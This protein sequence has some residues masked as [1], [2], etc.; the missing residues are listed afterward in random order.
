MLSMRLLIIAVLFIAVLPSLSGALDL[1]EA[2]MKAKQNDPEYL[3]ALYEHRATLTLPE[4]AV[5]RVLPQLSFF[6]SVSNYRFV[7]DRGVYNDYSAEQGVLSFRQTIFDLPSFIEISQSDK[8][9]KAS[10]AKLINAELNLIRRVSDAYFEYIYAEEFLRV[11]REEKKA[12]EQQLTLA[13]RLFEAGESSLTDVHDAEARYYDV[14]F[15]ETE[16]E[17]NLHVKRRNLERLIGEEPKQVLSL[18]R[19]LIFENL[20]PPDVKGWSEIVRNENPY[21]RFFALQ[22]EIAEDELRKQ[23]AQW[24]PNLS[25]F[26]SFTRT[27]TRDYLEV[28]P[29]S[30]VTVGVQINWNIL[31][32]GYY[33]AKTKEARERLNQ[34]QKDY[35]KALSDMIQGVV[36][37]FFSVKS[38]QASILSTESLVRANELALESTKKGFAAG[39]RTF[40]D[41]LNAEANLYKAKL[42]FVKSNHDYVKSLINLYFYSGVLSEE[43]I[44]KINSWLSKNE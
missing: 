23:K 16:A 9:T 15:R 25:I 18:Q 40:V 38:S 20:V 17:R 31:S 43:H 2:Y 11:L 39:I 1:F 21:V 44:R 5:S 10:E 41:I 22:R 24:L 3:S 30:Y 35:E 42:N 36:D 13:K 29:L 14:L 6:Y 12:F 4:Q 33:D 32:G 8:R 28:K 34:A 37:S 7:E 26:S 27:N 19:K